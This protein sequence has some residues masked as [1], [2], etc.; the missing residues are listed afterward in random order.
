MR[1][2]C[3]VGAPLQQDDL[4]SA[5]IRAVRDAHHDCVGLLL[6]RGAPFSWDYTDYYTQHSL[7]N[8]ALNNT[9]VECVRLLIAAHSDVNESVRGGSTP[10]LQVYY[11][12]RC[13][14]EGSSTYDDLLAIARLLIEAGADVNTWHPLR[15]SPLM[16]AV[17]N[18]VPEVV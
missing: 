17:R 4:R 12:L 1:F 8:I 15:S 6:D 9:C 18:G 11:W 13:N 16:N 7:F 10:L 14:I 3:D 5:I 2:L